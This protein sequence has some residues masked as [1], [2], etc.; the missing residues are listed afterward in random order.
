MSR[1]AGNTWAHHALAAGVR[2]SGPQAGTPSPSRGHLPAEDGPPAIKISEVMMTLDE[3]ADVLANAAE[4]A[5]NDIDRPMV[6]H[7]EAA[8]FKLL[9]WLSE[10][11]DL[12]VKD[13]KVTPQP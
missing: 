12:A 1:F 10:G 3:F 5:R 11:A 7:H 4:V 2:L 6:S 9:D 13:R 8:A